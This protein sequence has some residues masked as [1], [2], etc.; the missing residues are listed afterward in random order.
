MEHCAAERRRLDAEWA[1][2]HSA[3]KQRQE[4]LEKEVRSL[5]EKR[6][7][8]LISLANVSVYASVLHTA[9]GTVVETDLGRLCA[10]QR[11]GML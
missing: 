9:V 4:Q 5:L 7:S 2:F 10:C 11:Y 3:E 1:N 6:E 8:A